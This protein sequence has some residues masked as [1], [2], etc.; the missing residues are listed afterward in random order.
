MSIKPVLVPDHTANDLRRLMD[1]FAEASTGPTRKQLAESRA[2]VTAARKTFAEGSDD[3]GAYDKWDPKHPDFAKNYKKFQAGNPGATLKDYIADLKKRVSENLNEFL[4]PD[5]SNYGGGGGGGD[6]PRQFRVIITLYDDSSAEDETAERKIG[7]TVTA[8]SEKAACDLATTML[9]K[10]PRY[11]GSRITNVTAR[12]VLDEQTMSRAAKGYEKYGRA[13][14]QALAKAGREGRALD[15]VRDRYDRYDETV[16][17]GSAGPELKA[18]DGDYY[19]DSTDFFSMF[20]QD[21]FDREE[22]SADGMEIRGY[23]DDV[24]VMVFKYSTPDRMGGWGNYDDSALIA[25]SGVEDDEEGETC[26]NCDGA[27]CEECYGDEDRDRAHDH[28]QGMERESVGQAV[29]ESLIDDDSTDIR[30]LLNFNLFRDYESFKD[31]DIDPASYSPEE[32]QEWEQLFAAWGPVADQLERQINK[33]AAKGAVLTPEQNQEINDNWYDGSDAYDDPLRE[34]PGIYAREIPIIRKIL[35]QSIK[36]LTG[37]ADDGRKQQF[38]GTGNAGMPR[39]DDDGNVLE[40]GM[41]EAPRDREDDERHDLDPSDWY[42]VIDGKLMKA[43]V[44]PNQHDQARAEGFSPTREQARARAANKGM[45]EATGQ[46]LNIQQ[47]ATISDEALDNAY[48]YGRSTPGNT[49][50]WQANLKSAAYAKQMIDQGV[51]DIEAISDAIHKGWNVTARAFVQKPEQFSDTEKL[52]AAGKLEAKLQQREKLMN[53]GYAQL[54]DEEQE[55]DRVVAR[56]LLQALKG[57]SG[58]AEGMIDNIK[59]TVRAANY[60][61]LARRSNSQAVAGGGLAPPAQFKSLSAKGDQRAQKAQDIRKG[62]AEQVDEKSEAIRHGNNSRSI[63][64]VDES[65]DPVEQLRADIK[66]FAQ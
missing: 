19:E 14:M 48:H 62:S 46:Q 35:R 45:S 9:L 55:K 49:F 10:S 52:R 12:P 53:I 57:Q 33:A 25:E 15:P 2:A 50:G 13:G 21:H 44:Y 7:I 66:R 26:P 11:D 54:P 41:A 24:C 20:D 64:H 38:R 61:R 31:G 40:Q 30:E 36:D 47:L 42:I 5:G 17:E 58:V 60:D 29:Q 37:M 23:I 1:H 6:E 59:N 28:A 27:G 3:S 43:S 4:A 18:I 56:A 39:T 51:T 63:Y 32:I 34:L 65:V 8:T 22:E 16:A